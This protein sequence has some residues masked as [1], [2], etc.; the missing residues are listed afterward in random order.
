MKGGHWKRYSAAL[1]PSAVASAPNRV[2]P[3][4]CKGENSPQIRN[5]QITNVLKWVHHFTPISS[6]PSASLPHVN[7]PADIYSSLT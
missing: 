6:R 7:S 5:I 1:P 2:I 4:A 3:P